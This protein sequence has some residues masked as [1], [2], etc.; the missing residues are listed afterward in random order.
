MINELVIMGPII[1]KN[2]NLVQNFAL[3]KTYE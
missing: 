1:S 3:D 2:N